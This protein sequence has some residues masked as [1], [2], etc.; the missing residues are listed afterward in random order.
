[1]ERPIPLGYL[2]RLQP[3]TS[4]YLFLNL[5]ARNDW[6]S[7]L[8]NEHR[9]QFYPSAS[10]SFI[11]SQ[12]WEG[13]KTKAGFDLL[14]LR[15]GYG[16]SAGFPPLYVTESVLAT[17]ARGFVSR[18]GTV[19]PTNGVI[20]FWAIPIY[21]RSC[22]QK[23]NWDWNWPCLRI[24]LEWILPSIQRNTKNLITD[25]SL[26]PSTGYSRTYVNIGEMTNQ[27]LEIGTLS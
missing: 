18:D 19:V 27:G 22:M 6:F 16:T 9:S 25:A 13:L 2:D 15:V 26:D 11:A 4:N 5:S 1:M 21:S 8:Q 17:N 12:L 3:A 10:L 7:S 14:K 24:A 20:S 23:Q